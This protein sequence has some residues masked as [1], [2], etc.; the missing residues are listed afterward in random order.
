MK[1]YTTKTIETE[2]PL[3]EVL[4]EM[5]QRYAPEVGFRLLSGVNAVQ[6]LD[7]TKALEGE[8]VF[9]E[10]ISVGFVSWKVFEETIKQAL[11]NA[12]T[13]LKNKAA[14]MPTLPRLQGDS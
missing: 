2:I 9:V 4:R 10:D 14:E 1:F 6:I 8:V 13:D 12:S 5:F 3:M 7:E 11:T